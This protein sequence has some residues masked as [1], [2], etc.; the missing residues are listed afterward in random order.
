MIIGRPDVAVVGCGGIGQTHAHRL[1]RHCDLTFVSRRRTSAEALASRIPG[2]IAK[3]FNEVLDRPDIRGMVL[4]TPAELHAEQAVRALRAGKVVLVEKPM[5]I[6]PAGVRAI[7]E[8]LATR[9]PGAL[10]VAE[11]YLYK[12]L[13][14]RLRQLLPAVGPVRRVELRKLTRQPVR[15]WRTG[16]GALLEGGI[17][18]VALLGAIL[19]EDPVEVTGRFPDGE[20]PER[21]SRVVARYP[22]GATGTVHYAWNR[23]SLPGG[24]LQHSRV[25]GARGRIVFESNG[26]W[27]VL[28]TE[29]RTRIRIPGFSDLMGFDAMT[30]DF[31][32]QLADPSRTP[33]SDFGRA[34]RDLDLVFAAYGGLSADS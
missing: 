1:R 19:D 17:H 20:R 15:G 7:G 13:A 8:A 9:E 32:R 26:L 21:H 22:S 25:E 4:A 29:G 6:T 30:R 23:R 34:R 27:L 28:R 2:R 11:N 3:S 14:K 31:R 24:I 18:F 5:A 16:L 33:L 12:P 10:M